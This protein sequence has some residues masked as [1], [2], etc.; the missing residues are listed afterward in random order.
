MMQVGER[1]TKRESVET[2]SVG[3]GARIE[4]FVQDDLMDGVTEARHLDETMTG[5]EGTGGEESQKERI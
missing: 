3:I 5:G 4:G 1:R 2:I